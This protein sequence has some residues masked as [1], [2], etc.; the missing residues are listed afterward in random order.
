MIIFYISFIVLYYIIELLVYYRLK[1][2]KFR[3]YKKNLSIK[4]DIIITRINYIKFS[5]KKII[6]G[7]IRVLIFIRIITF[8]IIP[9]NILFFYIYRI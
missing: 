3:Y 7:I 6:K 4:L 1:N 2:H 5:K 8:Y 9:A